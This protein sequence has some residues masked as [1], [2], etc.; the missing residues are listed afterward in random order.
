MSFIIGFSVS[1]ALLL[2]GREEQ[3]RELSN[4]PNSLFFRGNSCLLQY[5]LSNLLYSGV[6]PPAVSNRF[7]TILCRVTEHSLVIIFTLESMKIW[8]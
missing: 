6:Q 2:G 1:C 5:Y 7:A 8:E 4:C 3:G